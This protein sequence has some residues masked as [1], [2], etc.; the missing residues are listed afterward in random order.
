MHMLPPSVIFY[1]LD[2]FENP[3]LT[4]FE[5]SSSLR[6]LIININVEPKDGV[7][8]IGTCDTQQSGKMSLYIYGVLNNMHPGGK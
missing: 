6:I 3:P 8:L 1:N 4:Q 5:A 7:S 2:T